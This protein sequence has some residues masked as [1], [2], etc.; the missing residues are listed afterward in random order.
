[1]VQE[2]LEENII[3]PSQSDFSSLVVMVYKKEGS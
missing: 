2:M 1:M 3:Q